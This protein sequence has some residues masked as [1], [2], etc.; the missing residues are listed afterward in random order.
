M[1]KPEKL[2]EFAAFKEDKGVLEQ[3]R[4]IKRNNKVRFSEK[5]QRETGV[6]VNPDSIFIVQ[7]KR[8]HEYKRQLLNALR[9]ISRYNQL[10]QNTKRLTAFL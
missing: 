9:I 7:A 1:T 4:A 8:L 3:L 6:V 2:A 10:K 5:L